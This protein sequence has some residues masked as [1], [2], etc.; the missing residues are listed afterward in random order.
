MMPGVEILTSEEVIISTECNWKCFWIAFSI[1]LI[2]TF[3]LT[4]LIQFIDS[5][6]D[7]CW[8]FSFNITFSLGLF[9]SFIAGALF[10]VGVFPVSTESETHY[11]V[12]IAEEVSMTDFLEQ[13]E[14]I[15]QD[16]KIFTI[17]E[18]K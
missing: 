9:L 7:I 10:G 17:R 4:V 2:A 5:G 14:I 11:K 3:L 16:G 8:S 6:F 12:T 13:Y 1:S 18:L 15:E